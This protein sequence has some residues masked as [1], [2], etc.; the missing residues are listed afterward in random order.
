[1]QNGDIISLTR[2]HRRPH[3]KSTGDILHGVGE[4]Q[5]RRDLGSGDDPQREARRN[6]R[7]AQL[8]KLRLPAVE[9]HVGGRPRQCFPGIGQRRARRR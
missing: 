8:G 2:R 9:I 4:G 7:T 1:M 3:R 5:R 6:R